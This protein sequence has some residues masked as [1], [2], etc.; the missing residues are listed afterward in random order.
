MKTEQ[1]ELPRIGNRPQKPAQTF[2]DVNADRSRS[3]SA[4]Q[5]R[6]FTEIVYGSKIFRVSLLQ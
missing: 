1:D 5:W 2:I 4:R 3:S 6:K